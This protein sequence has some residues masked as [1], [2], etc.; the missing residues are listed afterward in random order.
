MS[1]DKQETII[2]LEILFHIAGFRVQRLDD[3]VLEL[4]LISPTGIGATVRMD[5]DNATELAESLKPPSKI[6]TFT[7][8]P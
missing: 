2:P 7:A 4:S 8:I 3:D 1:E 6:D 5:Q